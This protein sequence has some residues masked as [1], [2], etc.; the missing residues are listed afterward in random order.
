MRAFRAAGA[1]L[2]VVVCA[3][4]VA[5]AVSATHKEV[6]TIRVPGVQGQYL[7]STF[8]LSDEGNLLVCLAKRQEIRVLSPEGKQTAVWKLPFLPQAICAG[9]GGAVYVGGGGDKLARL[10]KDG[11]VD[12]VVDLPVGQASYRGVTAVAASGKDLFVA[13]RNKAGLTAYRYDQAL[14]SPKQ[15]LTGLRGC[16]GQM[17]LIARGGVVYVADNTRHRVARYDRDG[18]LLGTFGSRSRTDVKGF[19]SCC[20]PMNLCFSPKGEICTS[21]SGVARVKRYSPEGKF[22]GLVGT[23]AG[24]SGCVHVAVAVSKDGSRVYVIDVGLSTIRVLRRGAAVAA[25]SAGSAAAGR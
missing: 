9:S 11:K 14:G 23:Y 4:G 17:H 13:F 8:C 16:C 1:F 25:V 19:G 21:E 18:K 20:N 15:V 3:G 6:K 12:R 24:A 5:A 2:C 10:T 7:L 22:L